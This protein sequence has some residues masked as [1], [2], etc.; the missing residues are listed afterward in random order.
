ME[1]IQYFIDVY[2]EKRDMNMLLNML[3]YFGI[4]IKIIKN[5]SDCIY[6]NHMN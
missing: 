1:L 2:M 3:N 6:M 5:F 4:V